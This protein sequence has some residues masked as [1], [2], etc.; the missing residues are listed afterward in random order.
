[1]RAAIVPLALLVPWIAVAVRPQ[2]PSTDLKTFLRQQL[3]FTASD[4]ERL[5]EGG[6]VVKLPKTTEVREV[7]V[8]A[9]M[10][11]NVSPDLFIDHVRDIANFA[12][13]EHVL[14]VG[15]FTGPPRFED[16]TDLTFA[17]ADLD[18]LRRCKPQRCDIKLS[19]AAMERFRKEV[20]WTLKDYRERATSLWKDVLVEYARGYLR[21]GNK[22]LM[23]YDDKP[24]SLHIVDEF[25]TLLPPAA[26]NYGYPPELQKFLEQFPHER[27][28]A[29]EDFLYWSKD[30]FGLKPVVTLT[31]LTIHKHA[32]P[33]G[34]IVQIASKGLYASHYLESSLGM[35]VFIQGQSPNP[36]YLIYTNRTRTDA[37]R[38]MLAGLK[39]SLIG[40]TVRDGAKD[41]MELIR[42]K[43]EG[44]PKK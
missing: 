44:E 5:D 11:I 36:S 10:R 4:I 12:K 6:V 27:P 42:K 9:I 35:T 22:A 29:A 19:A 23:V 16:L 2:A 33:N 41:N 1:M 37:L 24:S 32:G 38:G 30:T 7:A 31:H 15:K 43:L 8:F 28:A 13:S 34:T 26:Y 17:P 21:D 14:Q 18:A 3:S 20:D 39:R 25:K 40:G